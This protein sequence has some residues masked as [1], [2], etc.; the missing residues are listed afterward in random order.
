MDFTIFLSIIVLGCGVYC[1]YAA[2]ALKVKGVISGGILIPKE[3]NPNK[4][5]D[6]A[7]YTK[8]VLPKL[9]MLGVVSIL[10]GAADLVNTFVADIMVIWFIVMVLF[11]VVLFTFAMTISKATKTYF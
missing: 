11:I 2:Y 9:L 8:C 5:K 1:F 3:L 4:C 10:Y 7:A 6:K